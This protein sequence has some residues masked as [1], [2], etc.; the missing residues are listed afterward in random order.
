MTPLV[1]PLAAAILALGMAAAGPAQAPAKPSAPHLSQTCFYINQ[2][3]GFSAAGDS[4][5]NLRV[6]VRDVWQL[7]LF[8]PCLDIDWSQRIGLKTN[9][10]SCVV[11][12]APTPDPFSNFTGS[13]SNFLSICLQGPPCTL[14]TIGRLVLFWT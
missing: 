9:G 12:A 14:S 5:V 7:T 3:S 6:G 4:A 8:A 1:R 11:L 2:T 10:S 13:V